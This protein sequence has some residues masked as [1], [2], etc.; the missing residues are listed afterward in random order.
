[1]PKKETYEGML[2]K[3]EEIVKDMEKEELSLEDSIKKYEEGVKL[4]NKIY[5][6]LNE[7][8]GKIKVLTEDGE[9]NF[10]EE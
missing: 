5:K 2:N 9:K 3:L 1:M 4:S 10:I 7:A 8:E 6:I